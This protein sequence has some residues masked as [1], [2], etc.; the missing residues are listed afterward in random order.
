MPKHMYNG[1]VVFE[2][3]SRI[4]HQLQIEFVPNS[5]LLFYVYG[6][7]MDADYRDE[8]LSFR[9]RSF[10]RRNVWVKSRTVVKETL[11]KTWNL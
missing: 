10:F 11:E 3:I 4:K 7:M 8:E 6:K 1:A 9:V 2:V 5:I